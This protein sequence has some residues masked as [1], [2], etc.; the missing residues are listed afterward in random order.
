MTLSL[1][2]MYVPL[3]CKSTR[4]PCTPSTSLEVAA[5]SWA[6][7]FFST[8]C[9]LSVSLASIIDYVLCLASIKVVSSPDVRE[10]TFACA[11]ALVSLGTRLP[12]KVH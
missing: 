7:S 2:Y 9:R 3:G 11:F 1:H 12:S 6:F 10:V 8:L 4:D 5:T